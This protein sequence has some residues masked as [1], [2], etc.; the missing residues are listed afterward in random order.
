MEVKLIT[1]FRDFYDIWFDPCAKHELRRVTTD[2]MNRSEMF[3]FFR[4]NEIATVKYGSSE[5]MYLAG[6]EKLVVYTD[7]NSHCGEGKLLMTASEAVNQL[8]N[9][10]AS[11]YNPIKRG[12]SFRHLQLGN[13][14]AWMRYKSKDDW[15]SN[16]GEV[17]IDLLEVDCG[18]HPKVKLPIFA[19]DYIETP[20]GLL[21]I[22]LNIAPG[23]RGIGL[24]G[25]ITP[26]ETAKSIKRAYALFNNIQDDEEE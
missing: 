7:L 5:A 12:E 2:G 8:P 6:C 18:Y 21:A 22:D 15:R 20:S 10:L 11:E 4:K 19:I 3:K 23:A 14:W 26:R 13:F 17:D 24:E 16:N 25:V 1:N 9:Y